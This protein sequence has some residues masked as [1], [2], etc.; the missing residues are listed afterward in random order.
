MD[1]VGTAVS[2]IQSVYQSFGA[3]LLEPVTG[4][5][6]HNRGR[7]FSLRAGSANEFV[8]GTRPAHTLSPVLIHRNTRAFAAVGTM[9]G[10]AQP[11]ILAQLIPALFDGDRPLAEALCAPRWVVGAADIGF[12]RA[13]VAIEADAP[14][15]LDAA[16]RI[17]DLDVQRIPSR[18][19]R[20][21]H[22]Q[23]VRVRSDGALEA[24]ADPRSDGS[25]GVL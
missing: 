11:Q 22:A 25:S 19:E 5:L 17:E 13:T 24:A 2:L 21:G 10:R 20:V 6:F 7:G 14:A 23:L 3:A 18:D 9:G 4:V 1:S 12:A 8:P 16:L 15:A